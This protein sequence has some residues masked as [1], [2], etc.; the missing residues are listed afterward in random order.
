MPS[1]ATAVRVT[2]AGEVLAL[3]GA[4]EVA[5]EGAGACWAKTPAKAKRA[6][7]TPVFSMRE[8]KVFGDRVSAVMVGKAGVVVRVRGQRSGWPSRRVKDR[9]GTDTR[10]DATSAESVSPEDASPAS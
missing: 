6:P 7:A 4:L 2:T 10:L 9:R 8:R 1:A 3:L 5:R